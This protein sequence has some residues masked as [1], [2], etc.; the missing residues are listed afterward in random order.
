VLRGYPP[1]IQ[2]RSVI[3]NNEILIVPIEETNVWTAYYLYY[4]ALT[5]KRYVRDVYIMASFIRKI[6]FQW[7]DLRFRRRVED[8][9]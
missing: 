9:A 5:G 6:I 7:S 3:T 2:S 8:Q 4:G 1:E